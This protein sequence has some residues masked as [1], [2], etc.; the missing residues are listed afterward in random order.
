MIFINYWLEGSNKNPIY[1]ACDSLQMCFF[2]KKE[3]FPEDLRNCCHYT[4]LINIYSLQSNTSLYRFTYV[5][6]HLF[7]LHNE[8]MNFRNNYH[9]VMTQF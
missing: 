3:I 7:H 2:E 1:L 5:T 9:S 4:L 6:S 8:R